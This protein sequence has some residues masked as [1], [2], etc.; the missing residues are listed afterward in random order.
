MLEVLS[1]FNILWL[2]VDKLTVLKVKFFWNKINL[3]DTWIWLC[4][5]SVR[6][7][8]QKMIWGW[9]RYLSF[10]KYNTFNKYKTVLIG[11][12]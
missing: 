3:S 2:Y 7:N 5:F 4:E 1:T 10:K 6:Q 11:T 9:Y 8:K 12:L